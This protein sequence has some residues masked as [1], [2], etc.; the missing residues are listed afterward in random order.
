M[1]KSHTEYILA[2][3]NYAG[4]ISFTKVAERWELL[5]SF[6]KAI[7]TLSLYW[8]SCILKVVSLCAQHQL[9]LQVIAN[10]ML[11]TCVYC[12]WKSKHHFSQ[13]SCYHRIL[14]IL[15]LPMSLSLIPGCRYSCVWD[16]YAGSDLC[17]R[18]PPAGPHLP[19][20]VLLCLHQRHPQEE[21]T[22]EGG[23]WRTNSLL[24]SQ[25]GKQ[26]SAMFDLVRI[27]LSSLFQTLCV[28]NQSAISQHI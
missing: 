1:R 15:G 20:R 12:C 18:C 24:C 8:C 10:A 21:A 5:A 23:A 17:Q 26:F 4:L 13:V 2:N 22:R 27:T 6:N 16:V 11:C 14:V 9:L 19:W 25:E 28:V 3:N 7:M